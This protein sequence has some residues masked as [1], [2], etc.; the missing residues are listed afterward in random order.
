ML[1]FHLSLLNFNI[2]SVN[3]ICANTHFLF[4]TLFFSQ[5]SCI[6]TI[7]AI[8]VIFVICT[9]VI[10]VFVICT[11]LI[12]VICNAAATFYFSVNTLLEILCYDYTAN[13]Y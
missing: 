13:M 11:I 8:S 1:F 3:I 12:L 4:I 2:M 6:F 10:F 9:F 7:L 5:N